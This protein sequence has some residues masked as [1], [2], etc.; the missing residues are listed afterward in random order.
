[1]TGRTPAD[2]SSQCIAV[3]L[4]ILTRAVTKVYND[5]RRWLASEGAGGRRTH[6]L[7]LIPFFVL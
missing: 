7:T 5:A 3:K 4:R 1:M 6:L 2:I